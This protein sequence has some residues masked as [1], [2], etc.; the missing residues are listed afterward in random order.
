LAVPTNSV[1]TALTVPSVFATTRR[2]I[3]ADRG[4]V[5]DAMRGVI[6]T[7]HLFKTRADIVVPLLQELVG[8]TDRRAVERLRDHHAPL[9]P[10]LPRPDL[11]AGLQEIRDLFVGRYPAARELR[12]ADIVDASLIEEIERSGFVEE[13]YGGAEAGRMS[14]AC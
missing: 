4:C 12:E 10:A 5:L 8:C 1:L 9:F 13:L 3:A 7:I 14:R 6:E 2:M 11:A